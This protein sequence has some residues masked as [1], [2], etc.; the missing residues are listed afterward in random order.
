MKDR[1]QVT[2]LYNLY[3]QILETIFK[4][5]TFTHSKYLSARY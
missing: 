1:K 5:I 3:I 2:V 4:K